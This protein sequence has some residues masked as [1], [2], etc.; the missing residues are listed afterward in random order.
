[1]TDIFFKE[2]QSEDGENI[3]N[4]LKEVQKESPFLLLNDLDISLSQYETALE[5]IKES[6]N[7]FILLAMDKNKIVGMVNING[8][9]E[10]L[11]E[12]I[13]ELGISVK[14]EYWRQKI[15]ETLLDEALYWAENYSSLTRLEIYVQK[16]NLPALHLYEKLGFSKEGCLKNGVRHLN[17]TYDDVFVLAKIFA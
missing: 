10:T 8:T 14:K 12:H 6:P 9:N 3:L 2:A 15:G 17:G 1:M 16:K 5:W 11:R 7:Y 13:G 4:Y